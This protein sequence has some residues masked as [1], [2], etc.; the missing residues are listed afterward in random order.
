MKQKLTI[1]ITGVDEP[2]PRGDA[3]RVKWFF[4]YLQTDERL[5]SYFEAFNLAVTG[6]SGIVFEIDDTM[7]HVLPY[8]PGSGKTHP[9]GP[10]G[11][12]LA[13]ANCWH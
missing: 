13:A 10:P 11:R 6:P 7:G 8:L 4:D 2:T 12:R 5:D 3:R 1:E 9:D